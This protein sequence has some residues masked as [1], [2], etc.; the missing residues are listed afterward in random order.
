MSHDSQ[1]IYKQLL[2]RHG[3]I[4]I[5]KIQRDFAQG[6]PAEKPVREL[7]LMAL[8]AALRKPV[9]DP[10]LPL[11]LDFIYGSVEDQD[12]TFI[13]LDGQQR[14]TTLFL[15]HWYLAWRDEEWTIFEAIFVADKHARF[16]YD[17][18]PSSQ[19]FFDQLV[20][21]RPTPHPEDIP[22]WKDPT[23]DA[24]KQNGPIT[25]LI[26]DQPWYFRRYR[27]DPT[28]QA[29]LLM[30][31][32]IHDKFVSSSGLF[33]RLI[34]ENHPAITFQLLDLENFGL[35]D[36]LYIKMNARGKPLTP[37]ETFKARYE[38]KLKSQFDKQTFVLDGH[39]FSVAD[40][41]ARRMDTAWTDLFWKLREP[42]SH[43][44]DEAFMN[45]TRAVAL[46]TR[47]PDDKNYL[48]DVTMLIRGREVPSYTDFHERGWLD[49]RF[50][51]TLTHLLDS[52]SNES[53]TISCFLPNSSY[54]DE[55]AFFNK[56]ALNRPLTTIRITH[57]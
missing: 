2:D 38:E 14:L 45:L 35:S 39:H 42:N 46:I 27:L 21:F 52:W 26:T 36:D 57:R 6:R 41:V 4:Q 7:F 40:Y 10:T 19:D 12:K 33:A 44:F 54:F 11:N 17:V 3:R 29:V 51:L 30:L 43:Q 31:D 15:L 23:E 5:P 55:K 50:T 49:E 18:R 16:T 47:A 25:D 32:D 28:I 22:T 8:D 20:C 53:G 34:D 37:F 9:G 1:I 13:P 48:D 56:I 24:L